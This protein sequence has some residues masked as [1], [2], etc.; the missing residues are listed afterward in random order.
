LSVIYLDITEKQ[1]RLNHYN[2]ELCWSKFKE[3]LRSQEPRTKEELDR[4]ITE[5]LAQITEDDVF[6]WFTYCGLFI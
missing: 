4:N 5:A 3:F 6:G 2:I 1:E